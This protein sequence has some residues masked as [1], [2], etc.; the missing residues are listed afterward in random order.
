MP[1]NFT[2]C[3][4]AL[5]QPEEMLILVL[6]MSR[7][8]TSSIKAALDQVGY[9]T[10]HMHETGT[11][12]PDWNEALA[13]KYCGQNE[14]RQNLDFKK[15]LSGYSALS[16]IPAIMFSE[17]LLI[18]YPNAKVILTLRDPVKW[19]R[20]VNNTL[21]PVLRW[22]S[23][24]ILKYMDREDTG[25]WYACVNSC[26]NIWAGVPGYHITP[27]ADHWTEANFVRY[28]KAHCDRIRALVPGDKLL[29]FQ[30]ADGWEP[31]CK[32]LDIEVPEAQ[33]PSLYNAAN[34]VQRA[35]TIWWRLVMRL[36][37]KM[38]LRGA[39]FLVLVAAVLI[40]SRY[41]NTP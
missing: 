15:L 6:G 38:L 4:Q 17:E 14:Q 30:A 31:L 2:D 11:S 27:L 24:K 16:D 39:G 36:A 20:S 34:A 5:A 40:T 19:F 33:Y 37:M 18:A 1:A 8:G 9:R 22:P 32:F 13:A 21:I 26:L 7:T 28:Y 35:T 3:H 12:L 41:R 29:E 25:S 23:W 10:Y